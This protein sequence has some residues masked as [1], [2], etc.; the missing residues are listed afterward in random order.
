M[1][2]DP[3]EAED[4]EPVN[5]DESSLRVEEV[6]VVEAY[7]GKNIRVKGWLYLKEPKRKRKRRDEE[8]R[9]NGR[10]SE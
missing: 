1:W 10:E 5:S 4:T 3:H 6:S 7:T 8:E 9:E 2:E